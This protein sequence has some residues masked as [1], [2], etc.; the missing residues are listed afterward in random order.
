[1]HRFRDI[2]RMLRCCR[3]TVMARIRE[4]RLK[5]VKVNG[6]RLITDSSLR[7]LLQIEEAS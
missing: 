7:E 1:M 3:S 2:E 5:S 4:G 6:M